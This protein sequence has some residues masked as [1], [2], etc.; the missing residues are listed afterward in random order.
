MN[1]LLRYMLI[2]IPAGV[3]CRWTNDSQCFLMEHLDTIC[4]SPS[5]IYHSA[6]PLSPHS[7]WLQECY[8]SEI[9]QEVKVVKGLPAGWGTCSRTVSFGTKVYEVSYC[10]NMIAVGSCHRDIIILDTI[11]GSRTA[12]LSGHTD[13]VYAVT[14]S[15]D[16]RSL[17]SGSDD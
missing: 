6:L 8:G 10:S 1:Q 16:G 9:L 11:T 14:F 2:I 5:Q 4:N 15:S 17:V 13:E 12:T 7:T 3:S